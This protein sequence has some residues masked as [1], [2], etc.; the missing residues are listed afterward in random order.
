MVNMI[1]RDARLAPYLKTLLED[2]GIEIGINPALSTKD[3]AAI[4]VDEYYAGLKLPT[5]PKAVDFVVVVDCQ[6]DCFVMYI[7]ELKNVNG[8]DKL[9]IAAIQEKFSN[10]IN[11]FLSD[12]FSDIFLN[13]RFK[14]KG[15][16]LYLISDAY[17]E[18]GTFA[19]HAEY[20]AFREKINKRDSLKVDM[21]LS[22]KLYRFRGKI[23]KIEYDIP[24][25]PII[26]RWQ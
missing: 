13:D 3:F 26:T 10:T 1:K 19:N 24:P 8:P 25:N 16:K 11:L 22:S 23:L 17:E 2:A 15:I 4:K 14:Y 18:V 5:T 21:S 6:C 20:L 7:L 12:A 9:D